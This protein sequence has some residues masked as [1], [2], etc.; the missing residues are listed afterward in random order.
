MKSRIPVTT[1]VREAI[2]N[3]VSFRW[4]TGALAVGVALIAMLSLLASATDVRGIVNRSEEVVRA[5][6][7]VMTISP[8]TDGAALSAARCDALQSV[9]GVRSAGSSWDSRV[10]TSATDNERW[11]ILTASAGYV[12]VVWPTAD[13]RESGSLYVGASIARRYGLVDGALWKIHDL[14]GDRTVPVKVM[15]NTK[16]FPDMDVA[17]IETVSPTTENAPCIAEA[18]S[19]AQRSV[20]PIVSSWFAPTAT[21]L[22]AHP[23]SVGTR[24]PQAEYTERLTVWAPLTGGAI[25]II[26]AVGFWKLRERD[27]ALYSIN[28]VSAGSTSVMLLIE[29]TLLLLIPT[30]IGGLAAAAILGSGLK[31]PVVLFVFSHDLLVLLTISVIAPVIGVGLLPKAT[32]LGR[33]RA[34]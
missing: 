17:A 20:T 22:T 30:S 10:V 27:F 14:D 29:A 26:L 1:L 8:A 32:A 28:R 16:R 4:L 11:R 12:A 13:T 31:D 34:G 25:T 9:S 7:N 23:T 6:V 33:L 15:P 19:G 5:G 18:T 2:A 3:V 21:K 24:S